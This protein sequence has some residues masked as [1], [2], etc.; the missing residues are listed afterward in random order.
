MDFEGRKRVMS[1]ASV[2]QI[3]APSERIREAVGL[4]GAK[5]IGWLLQ[6]AAIQQEGVPLGRK[7]ALLRVKIEVERAATRFREARE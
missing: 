7:G 1:C 6:K 5:T 4:T 2:P 3:G